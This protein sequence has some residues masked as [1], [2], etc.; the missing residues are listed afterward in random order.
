MRDLYTE[1]LTFIKEHTDWQNI[2]KNAP[3]YVNV[4][5]CPYINENL[6]MLGYTNT[7]D[8]AE[9][10]VRACR[11]SVISLEDPNNPKMVCAPFYKFGNYGESYCDTIDWSTAMVLDKIDGQLM[12]LFCYKNKWYWVTNKGWDVTLPI[13]G[14]I[15]SEFIEPE[16]DGKTTYWDLIEYVLLSKFKSVDE[17]YT[18]LD[19]DVTYMFELCGPKNRIIC[20]YPKTKLVFL[21]ARNKITHQEILPEVECTN[22]KCLAKFDLPE[23]FDLHDILTVQAQLAKYDDTSKEGVVIRDVAFNRVKIKCEHYLFLKY[24]KGDNLFT[25]D[26]ILKHIKEGCSDDL[27]A[28]FPEVRPMVD[29][30]FAEYMKAVKKVESLYKL[31]KA[32]YMTYL[33]AENPRR[34]YAAWVKTQGN[35]QRI[36]F[37]GLKDIPADPEKMLTQMDYNTLCKFNTMEF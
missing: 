6:Y 25:P 14:A 18:T 29:S 16:T 27:G 36:L 28:G 1:L 21:G 10:L 2:L 13:N 5:K 22:N 33:E 12:K 17:L 35:L 3:Y 19:K 8:F 31:A 26:G 34:E 20:N 30:V 9:P 23:I 37:E 24:L 11:G 7:S 4:T 15:P 32:K